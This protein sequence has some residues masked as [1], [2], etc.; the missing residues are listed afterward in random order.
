[1]NTNINNYMERR[2]M[3][4]GIIKKIRRVRK[5]ILPVV[6]LAAMILPMAPVLAVPP[7]LK[8]PVLREGVQYYQTIFP[9]GLKYSNGW[10]GTF[11]YAPPASEI[12][13]FDDDH[14][15]DWGIVIFS[16]PIGIVPSG[17]QGGTS[18]SAITIEEANIIIQSYSLDASTKPFDKEIEDVMK[19]D[20]FYNG[21]WV[22]DK[23]KQKWSYNPLNKPSPNELTVRQKEYITDTNGKNIKQVD[24]SKYDPDRFW[25]GGSGNWSDNVTHWSA[26]SGGA[27]GASLPTNADNVF[28][29]AN[30]F[31]APGQV[32]IVDVATFFLDMNWT[33]VT[34]T[35][36]M[37]HSGTPTISCY[38]SLTL[39]PAMIWSHSYNINFN[40]VGAHTITTTGHTISGSYIAG[41]GTYTLLDSLTTAYASGQSNGT[42]DTNGQAVNIIGSFTISG[43]NAKTLTLGASVIDSTAWNYSGTNLS[44][45]A[46][47]AVINISGTGA[48]IGGN[49]DYN[50]ASF[51]LNGTAHT[52]S[53]NNTFASLSLNST[54]AQTITFT[55]GSTQNATAYS[56]S[57]SSGFQHTLT[58][59]G[60]AGWDINQTA[61]A[62]T[63]DY[64]TIDHSTAGGGTTFNAV[65]GS[66]NGGNNVGWNFPLTI[67]TGV[68]SGVAMDRDGVMASTVAG[69][70]TD[71]GGSATVGAWWD[72]GLT[73]GYGSTTTNVTWATINFTGSKTDTLPINL[74]PGSTYHYRR[75][76]TSGANTTYGTDS[77]FIFTMPTVTTG[78]TSQNGL[79]A[80]LTGTVS[81]MGVATDTYGSFEWGYDTSYGN[82]ST[83]TTVSGIGDYTRTITNYDPSKTIYY[84]AIATNT[85][86]E[87]YGAGQSFVPSGSIP[88]AFRLANILPIIFLAIIIM[89]LVGALIVAEGLTIP[90]LVTLVLTIL[91]GVAGL[92]SIQAALTALWGGG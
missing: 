12:I 33:G 89:M 1:M 90:I 92:D 86:T 44:V 52:V 40:G 11:A 46:N 38:G 45:T 63:A 19:F 62:V 48:L 88:N 31:T 71:M 57:G 30:S 17:E 70:I 25:V 84:R 51:N 65:G 23:L 22:G 76:I 13:L 72:Y 53:G 69:T 4:N 85:P 24:L 10:Y 60:V 78:G 74:T 15:T 36:R 59:S 14:T 5:F 42:F 73:T 55:D 50:G 37:S 80:V 29:D 68:A 67:A 49:V 81:D 75:A 34:N 21:A 7:L 2:N 18:L 43:A 8:Y 61:G 79:I 27:P 16:M 6:L 82:S 54:I 58:G 47:T 87:V 91:V 9:V 35:P 32:I 20:H 66:I 77:E 28:F 64:I 26:T 56:L 3:F 83:Q 39:I 41:S